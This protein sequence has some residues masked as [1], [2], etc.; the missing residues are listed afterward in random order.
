MVLAVSCYTAAMR[1][2][3][4]MV[5]ALFF[6]ACSGI[7]DGGGGD[8]DGDGAG[9]AD[10][11]GGGGDGDGGGGSVQGSSR[12]FPDGAWFNQDISDAPVRP[13]S[14]AITAWMVDYTDNVAGT[15]PNGWGTDDSDMRIDF[16]IVVV[17]APEGADKMEFETVDDYYYPPDCDHAPM[18]LPPGGAV[19][20]L[21]GSPVDLS[22]M[23]GYDCDGFD[24]GADCHLLVFAPDESRLYEIYHATYDG[25]T[26]RGGCQ[27]IWD[28]SMVYGDTGRGPGCTS[29]DA[30]GFPIAPLLFRP[31]D[32]AD[33]EIAHAIRFIL[34]NPMIQNR[35]YVPPG[36]HSTNSGGPA[37]S[38]PYAA[39]FRLR[40]DYPVEELS[41]G[42]QVVARAMQRYGMYLS[43]GGDLALTA[44]N[45]LLLET[46]WDE[47]GLDTFSLEALRATDFEIVDTGERVDDDWNCQRDQITE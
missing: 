16:S 7:V 12:Y 2:V 6:G 45:D 39:L 14:D 10:G 11:G 37:E 8:D 26:F 41:P 21:Q 43:D 31:Q 9:D 19:E 27:A 36:S 28:T 30:A 20:R 46:S 38:V 18:P 33:G 3:G 5:A 35:V 34:P 40:A 29:A 13:D 47:V 22:G 17:D 23:E 1:Q 24:G 42:A 25:E 32:I 4:L 15:G 44:E